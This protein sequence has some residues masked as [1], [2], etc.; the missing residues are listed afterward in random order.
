MKQKFN[1]KNRRGQN[2][3]GV[4]TKPKNRDDLTIGTAVLQHGY[5]GVKEHKQILAMQDAFLKNG[6]QVFNFDATNSFGESDGEYENARLGL[7]ADDFD[8]VTNW[9]R[10]QDWF[11]GRLLVSGH[12]MGGFASAR[13]ALQN[14]DIV[15]FAIPLTP[16]ISGELSFVAKRKFNPDRLNDWSNNKVLIEKPK[17]FPDK[18]KKKPWQVIMEYF[19]HS[20][21]KIFFD[22]EM[23]NKAFLLIACEKDEHIPPEHIRLFYETLG[24]DKSFVVIDGAPHIPR[25]EKHLKKITKVIDS[26][27][28]ERL[29]NY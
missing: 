6:F 22:N 4:L 5:C 18:I 12:S 16:V 13:Y 15:D 11:T 26:W 3:V 19:N 27:L 7:H 8:D 28:K 2:I 23:K 9:V 24:E 1:L 20:L 25:E 17:T 10:K 29:K 21:I 14:F